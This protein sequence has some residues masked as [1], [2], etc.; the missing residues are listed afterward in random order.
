MNAEFT[1][2]LNPIVVGC[3]ERDNLHHI[4]PY[5]DC[6][7][8]AI[9]SYVYIDAKCNAPIIYQ[10]LYRDVQHCVETFLSDLSRISNIRVIT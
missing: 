4:P 2:K 6:H 8:S 10:V 9:E 3:S 5:L 1:E 7:V